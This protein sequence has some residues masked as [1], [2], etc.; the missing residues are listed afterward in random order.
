M[1]VRFGAIQNVN[2]PTAPPPQPSEPFDWLAERLADLARANLIRNPVEVIG[3]QGPTLAVRDG[4]GVERRWVNFCSN[5]YLNLAADPRIRQAACDAIARWGFGSGAS[6]LISGTTSLHRRAE[7]EL[8]DFL[9]ADDAILLATGY[10]TNVAAITALA[11][12]GD[13]VIVDKLDHASLIDA[14]R[15][16]G[17]RLRAYPHGDVDRLAELLARA[18]KSSSARRVFV[19]TDSLFS[20]DGDFAPLAEIVALKQR[21]RFT[22]IVDEAHAIGVF[23]PTGR[24][25]A[26]LLGL[27]DQ[28]DVL[29]GTCSKAMG[30]AGGFIA[31]RKVLIDA[32]RTTARPFI[33]STAPPAAVAAATI[34][35]LGIIGEEPQRRTRLLQLAADLHQMLRRSGIVPAPFSRDPQGSALS[36]PTKGRPAF[37]PPPTPII[38]VI[39]GSEDRALAA[40]RVLLEHGQF[41]LAIRPPTVPKGT[42]RLRISLMCD[43]TAA[44]LD[45]LV[46]ALRD[47]LI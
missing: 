20:M 3:A 1:K 37:A 32:L 43:H 33:Y 22:L 12:A 25:V 19:V 41:V 17:A 46:A 10:Q 4:D 13:T 40:Q 23:G 8:A 29:V 16:S 24:G 15:Q 45:R 36:N 21:F 11:G 9:G 2:Q 47:A 44:D 6:R 39:L 34:A 27:S 31:G 7:R 35:A 14:A 5:N 30:G 42:S 28:I 26:E 38:P 18:P